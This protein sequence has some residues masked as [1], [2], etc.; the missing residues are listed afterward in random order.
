[1]KCTLIID[2][3]KDEEIIIYAHDRTDLIN[4]IEKLILEKSH[5]LIGYNEK[6]IINLSISDVY[7]FIVENNKI[8]AI[9]ENEKILIKKRLY[10][11]ERLLS[12]DFIKINQSC[13]INIK[14]IKRFDASFAGSL[15]VTL[16]NDYKDYISRRQLKTVKERIGF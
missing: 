16:K 11:I 5:D 9:T 8:Y 2:K 3:N 1:M 15:M 7:C 14:K 10:E 4:R 13:I 12:N 6:S